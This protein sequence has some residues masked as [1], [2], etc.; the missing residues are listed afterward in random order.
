MEMVGGSL[1]EE[2]GSLK[3][4]LTWTSRGASSS[5]KGGFKFYG[6]FSSTVYTSTSMKPVFSNQSLGPSNS[7]TPIS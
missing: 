7:L 4:S 1:K 6:G 5:I 3:I 2:K